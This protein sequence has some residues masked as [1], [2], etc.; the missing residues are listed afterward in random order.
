MGSRQTVHIGRRRRVFAAVAA[1]LLGAGGV[2]I[3]QPAH[4]EEEAV[5]ATAQQE[6]ELVEPGLARSEIEEFA[7]R[8]HSRW[9]VT[10]NPANYEVA[11][12][13]GV[14]VVK[15]KGAP[16]TVQKHED[17]KGNGSLTMSAPSA[18]PPA[19]ASDALSIQ[20]EPQWYEPTC[21]ARL[22]DA[23]GVGWM[24]TC[25]QWGEMD[26]AGATRR[27]VAFKMYATCSATGRVYTKELDDCY[28]DS[29]KS[30]TSAT[31]YWNDWSPKSTV[32]LSNCGDI[33]LT[34]GY[35]GVGGSYT[36]HT[37]E[38]LVPL[39]G[40]A[41]GDFRATWYG[42]S[43]KSTDARETAMLLAIGHD[44]SATNIGLDLTWGYHYSSCVPFTTDDCGS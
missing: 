33:T 26:Y 12:I 16:L 32:S 7:G 29:I 42:E 8:I 34:V 2:L 28:V 17:S 5:T 39:K 27:N 22:A 37:C 6:S 21:Y 9:G 41:G 38:K 23:D 31:W 1:L 15:P 13:S 43:Y 44:W 11:I 35:G 3:G 30:A 14:K 36:L 18:A 19:P 40:T 25:S 24:D 10:V 20:S 4:A